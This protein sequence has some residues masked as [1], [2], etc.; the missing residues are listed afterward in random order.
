MLTYIEYIGGSGRLRLETKELEVAVGDGDTKKT[1][2]VSKGSDQTSLL[3]A[4]RVPGNAADWSDVALQRVG[5]SVE[6]YGLINT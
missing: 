2:N 1:I 4:V 5:V 6:V 3:F